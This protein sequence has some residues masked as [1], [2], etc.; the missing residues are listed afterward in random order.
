[1]TLTQRAPQCCHM[2]VQMNLKL[3]VKP[4]EVDDV[5]GQEEQWVHA[6]KTDGSLLPFLVCWCCACLMEH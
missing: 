2:A 5:L 4:K 6:Q 1:M 3:P